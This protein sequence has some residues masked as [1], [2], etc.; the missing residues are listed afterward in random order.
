MLA[1]FCRWYLLRKYSGQTTFVF[2]PHCGNELCR[3]HLSMTDTDL[4][5]YKCKCGKN[6]GW[7]F[8]APAPI[9]VEQK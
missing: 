1:R 6:S 5:R 2:C 4:V 7:L 3:N 8:D 9:L